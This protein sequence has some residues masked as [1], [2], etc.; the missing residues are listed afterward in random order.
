MDIVQTK[1]N[2][3][4][5]RILSL[6][7][8][9]A[10][11][12][13]TV[14][15]LYT[16][17][18]GVRPGFSQFSLFLLPI[19]FVGYFTHHTFEKGRVIVRVIVGILALGSFI[20]LF[21][22]TINNRDLMLLRLPQ[23]TPLTTVQL[24]LGIVF[25]VCILDLTRRLLGWALVVVVL[26]FIGYGLSGPVFGSLL[27]HRGITF[28]RFIEQIY[29][30]FNGI[31]GDPLYVCATFVFLFVLFGA[32]LEKG[33]G[34]EFFI[35][36][37]KS[38]VGKYRG[39][40]G[41]MVVVSSALV[42]TINGSAV[43]NVVTTGVFT[44]PLM[45]RVGY[46]KNYAGA[47]EAVASTGG[48]ILPPIM[49]AAAFMMAEYLGVPYTT[50]IK[51][52]VIPS[53]LYFLAVFL[54]VFL[55]ARR[56]GL[57]SLSKEEIPNWRNVLLKGG[58]ML[59]PLIVIIVFLV[60]GYSPMRAGFYGIVSTFVCS[61][62]N[63]AN[64]LGPKKLLS[65][66]ISA[67]K[68][69]AP[70]ACACASAGVIIAVIRF[71]GIGLK[72]SSVVL[73]LSQGNLFF[74]LVLTMCTSLILGMGL[75]TAA[76]YIIQA[77]LN[78]PAL[79]QLGLLPIQAH[80]F[81]FYFACISAIT[82]PVAIAAFAAASI[83]GGKPMV[84]SI[85][86]VKLGVVAFIVPY[87]FAYGPGILLIGTT[88]EIIQSFCT[89]VIGVLVLAWAL[90]GWLGTVLHKVLR[91]ILFAAALLLMHQGGITDLIGLGL[92][93]IVVIHQRLPYNRRLLK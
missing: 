54:Q 76:A 89:S 29:L 77:A 16:A 14:F 12:F 78:V 22:I 59:I 48:Q 90:T 74:A 33:G 70:V 83:S 92:A 9:I 10:A 15:Q 85:K 8:T 47:I 4:L 49:G 1:Q 51:H 60:R 50:I 64:M 32:L 24:V 37:S 26:V 72:F 55:E 88:L 79:I 2:S 65:A 66:T 42:G 20:S 56:L 39:G 93:I 52:A 46:D 82:P 34:G 3:G 57:A 19:M 38:L 35:E 80:M 40:P 87:M 28:S 17:L 43:A 13:L 63:K 71:T 27:Y 81:I 23:V 68:T 58:V 67:A 53:I 86:A 36:F 73:S 7:I 25:L 41:L 61:F 18:K 31:F 6:L 45:K 69:I 62:F 5:N 30:T 21:Y 91:L 84:T 11:V 75:P 44:I